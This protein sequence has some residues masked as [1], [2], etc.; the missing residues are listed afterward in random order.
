[1]N[2]YQKI[3]KDI[4]NYSVEELDRFLGVFHYAPES[5]KRIQEA[6]VEVEKAAKASE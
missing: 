2:Y 4:P 5:R 6:F 3:K 1:M